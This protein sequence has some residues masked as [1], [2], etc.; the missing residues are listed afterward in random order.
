MQVSKSARAAYTE[1]DQEPSKPRVRKVIVILAVVATMIITLA[2]VAFILRPVPARVTVSGKLAVIGGGY[3]QEI[4]FTDQGLLT[5]MSSGSFV[6][7]FPA[8]VSHS[9]NYGHYNVSL[10]NDATYS[11]EAWVVVHVW[12]AG[13]ELLPCSPDTLNLHENG[14]NLSVTMDLTC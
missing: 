3:Y 10:P 9:S 8:N 1:T 2:T 5:F 12:G 11:V 4:T 7:S 6:R 13:E 14:D